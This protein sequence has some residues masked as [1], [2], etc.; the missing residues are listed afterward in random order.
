MLKTHSCGEL[1]LENVGKIVT[2]AGW[3]NRRRDMGGVV[4]ID[5]RDRN[6]KTQVVVNSGRTAEGLYRRR[7]NSQR[8]CHSGNRGSFKTAV[9]PGKR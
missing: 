6:G 8:I 7:A 1:R 4:F 3:V 9:W 5:L 2:L